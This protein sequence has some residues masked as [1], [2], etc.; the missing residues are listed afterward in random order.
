MMD[1]KDDR[2][3]GWG[4]KRGRDEDRKKHMGKNLRGNISVHE[5]S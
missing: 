4:I 3:D 5:C 2:M 1:V